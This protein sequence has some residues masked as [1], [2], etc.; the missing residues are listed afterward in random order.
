MQIAE[1]VIFYSLASDHIRQ[2]VIDAV[3]NAE[4]VGV[5]MPRH[6]RDG[7][8]LATLNPETTFTADST[9]FR[10]TGRPA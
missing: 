4:H 6:D 7:N 9:P 2:L 5:A 8:K 1:C 10:S 3:F